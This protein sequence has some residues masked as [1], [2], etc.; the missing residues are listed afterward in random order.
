M[1]GPHGLS[2]RKTGSDVVNF[3]LE[4][5]L[6]LHHFTTGGGKGDHSWNLLVERVESVHYFLEILATL[7]PVP[8]THPNQ[9][10]TGLP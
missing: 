7:S 10:L 4:M 6:C 2:I 8:R 9:E 5:H 1:F 3:T